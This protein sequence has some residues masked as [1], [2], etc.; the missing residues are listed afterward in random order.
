MS[1]QKFLGLS[2]KAGH[3]KDTVATELCR[4]YGEYGMVRRAFAD[5]LKEDVYDL[6]VT[7]KVSYG[8]RFHSGAWEKEV[9]DYGISK[10]QFINSI[11]HHPEVRALLQAYGVA[12]RKAQPDYWIQRLFQ[13]AEGQDPVASRLIV[14][15]DCRFINEAEAIRAR[16]GQVYR[17]VRPGYNNRLTAE[18]QAHESETALDKYNFAGYIYNDGDLNRIRQQCQGNALELFIRQGAG[19]VGVGA[20]RG[21]SPRVVWVLQ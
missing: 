4:L 20:N 14:V 19:H 11:K 9:P 13:W 12:Q 21:Q 3:G 17:V 15:P 2:G 1:R 5:A 10:V 6:L 7:G 18:A 16:Q 8:M